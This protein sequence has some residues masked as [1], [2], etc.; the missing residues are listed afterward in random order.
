[1]IGGKIIKVCGMRDGVNIAAVEAL[2]VDMMGFIFYPK[3]PRYIA[4]RPA[5][6]PQNGARVGVFVNESL[7]AIE[8]S[9][10]E[11]A[12]DYVQLHGAESVEECRRVAALG[13]KVIKAFSVDEDFDFDVVAPYAACCE[14][15]V[16]DTK[17]SGHGGS[18][19]QFDWALLD[20]YCGST[21]FL[22]SGGIGPQD[23]SSI[24]EFS[25][26]RLAGYD[27]NSRFESAPAEKDVALL[28][29]FLEQLK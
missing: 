22:L 11:F 26:P 5:Y 17:C 21:P 19:E 28:T 4:A 29:N 9:K 8:S 7:G 18:G 10:E 14:L 16:F 2:G 27:L 24:K 23:G 20:N 15:F 3:S 6:L 12:L 25:H 13:V 1:M